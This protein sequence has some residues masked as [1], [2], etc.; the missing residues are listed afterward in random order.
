MTLNVKWIASCLWPSIQKLALPLDA[1]K[2]MKVTMGPADNIS[3]YDCVQLGCCPQAALLGRYTELNRKV[4]SD[5]FR[6]LG[7]KPSQD[8][9][10]STV[11][12]GNV[13]LPWIAIIV[14]DHIVA[15]GWRN[16]ILRIRQKTSRFQ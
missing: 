13:V 15:Q 14:L 12:I 2:C 11:C 10:S 16:N 4:G 8:W 1:T 7:G 9:V 6:E 3:S 5:P